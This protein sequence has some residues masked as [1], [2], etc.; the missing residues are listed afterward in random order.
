MTG[1]FITGIAFYILAYPFR[2]GCGK[3]VMLPIN[4]MIAVMGPLILLGA[5]LAKNSI[6]GGN[7]TLVFAL[8][9]IFCSWI[10]VPVTGLLL[11]NILC[12]T[13]EVVRGGDHTPHESDPDL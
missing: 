12:R 3:L 8:V 2:L 13:I 6:P 11:G 9:S 4:W 10:G 1:C 7:V 5:F